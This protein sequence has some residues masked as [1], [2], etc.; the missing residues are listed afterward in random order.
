MFELDQVKKR[1]GGSICKKVNAISVLLKKIEKKEESE[2]KY[3]GA[4]VTDEH[5]TARV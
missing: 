4:F 1:M 2:K 5:Q 3:M